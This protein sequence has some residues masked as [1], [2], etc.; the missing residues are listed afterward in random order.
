MQLKIQAQ[1]TS[2]QD[3]VDKIAAMEK[4]LEKINNL[5]D[6]TK[7]VLETTQKHLEVTRQD[8]DEKRHLLEHHVEKGGE[9]FGQATDLLNTVDESISDVEKLHSKLDR[10][11]N[12][13]AHNET[14]CGRFKEEMF[15]NID[16]MGQELE[17]C[18][19]RQ[20]GFLNDFS[21]KLGKLQHCM[22]FYMGMDTYMLIILH[23][24]VFI[25]SDNNVTT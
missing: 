20:V 18:K 24:C 12:V 23:V 15:K 21:S 8:R 1:K 7:C 6:T 19:S 10:T 13:H 9:L 25:D 5:F 22:Y 17:L 16:K 11:S 14:S 3:F 2:M 4:E